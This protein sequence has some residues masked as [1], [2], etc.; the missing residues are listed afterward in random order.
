[1]RNHLVIFF[2]MVSLSGFASAQPPGFRKVQDAGRF[3]SQLSSASARTTSMRSE[4]VQVKELEAISEKITS[5]GIFLFKKPGKIR[6]EYHTPF[7]Y[8]MIINQGKVTIRDDRKT[9]SFSSKGNKLFTSVNNIMLDCMQGTAL[10]NKDFYSTVFENDLFYLVSMK[11]VKQTLKDYFDTIQ[12]QIDKKTMEVT[13]LE[14]LEP[15]G[16]RTEITFNKRQP[17][18]QISDSDFMVK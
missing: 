15:S 7:K 8:L 14:M 16:D 1:M 18:A 13:G 10:D 4:F 12:I 9:N 3:K 5:S 11:P 2:I 6:M 17:N